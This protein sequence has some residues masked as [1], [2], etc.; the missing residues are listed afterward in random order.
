MFIT[1]TPIGQSPL[2]L[3]FHWVTSYR[4]DEKKGATAVTC[5]TPD[6]KSTTWH[7]EEDV[8]DISDMLAMEGQ[9]QD[10]PGDPD[11]ASEEGF[12][13]AGDGNGMI[14]PSSNALA[15]VAFGE[16]LVEVR[17]E[18]QTH[19]IRPFLYSPYENKYLAGA[20]DA[21]APNLATLVR[22][23]GDILSRRIVEEDDLGLDDHPRERPAPKGVDGKLGGPKRKSKIRLVKDSEPPMPS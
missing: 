22:E 20:I 2:T 23:L 15:C 7:V 17:Y 10:L 12:A 11:D 8:E 18:K 19:S 9:Y 4:F 3:N 16:Y 5:V 6:G 13:L 14:S 21:T 1:V